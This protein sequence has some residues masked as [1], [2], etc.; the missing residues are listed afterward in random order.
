MPTN[1]RETIFVCTVKIPSR[2]NYIEDVQC[3]DN[4]Q[5]P[6]RHCAQ[7]VCCCCCCCCFV[8][9]VDV[10]VVVVVIV[11]VVDDV[12]DV[13]GVVVVV[14]VVISNVCDIKS[15]HFIG[16]LKGI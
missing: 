9:F 11:D 12:V 8:E 4:V 1:E 7:Y 10:G 6:T 15:S 16:I 3:A 2:E 5:T 14:D 13:I